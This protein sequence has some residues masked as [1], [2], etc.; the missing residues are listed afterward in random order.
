M[1]NGL[2]VGDR[3]EIGLEL[4][5]LENGLRLGELE[6]GL[7]LGDGV[8]FCTAKGDASDVN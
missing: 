8:V 2:L 6:N 7:R 4:R 5:A 3:L 1:E